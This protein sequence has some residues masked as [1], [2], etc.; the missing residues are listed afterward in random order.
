M[1]IIQ[2][3]WK[4]PKMPHTH[5]LVIKPPSPFPPFLDLSLHPTPGNINEE[6]TDELCLI[7]QGTQSINMHIF[8]DTHSGLAL[9]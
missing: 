8:T 9:S 3:S 4:K 1:G 6:R 2:M 7:I 5:S